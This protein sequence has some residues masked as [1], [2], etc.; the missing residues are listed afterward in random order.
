MTQ[1]AGEIE[2]ENI[3]GTD[4]HYY[5]G[6]YPADARLEYLLLL[7]DEPPTPDPLCPHK[8]LSGLGAHSEL[9][10]PGYAYHP[11]FASAARRY[12]RRLRAGYAARSARRNH[13]LCDGD[14]CVYAS[15]I[16]VLKRRY[17]T[18]YLLDGRDYIEYAHTPAVLDGLIESGEIEPVIAVFVTPPNR[19]QPD[20]PNRTTEYGLNP[21]YARFMAEELVPFVE[22]RYRSLNDPSA[23]LVAGPSYGGLAAAYVPLQ[24]PKVFGLGYS[25]SG[26]LSFGGNALIEAYEQAGPEADSPLCGYWPVR[27]E[28]GAG[29][30][31][32]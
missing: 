16:S 4:V 23:R 2:M 18:I 11:V 14:S 6:V 20:M 12:A 26:Y 8:V 29:V 19:H 9:V 10:M 24:H 21:D 30:A 28:S 32:G 15:R 25:Q 17:P 1:W 7:N 31:S 27:A 13:G 22:E 3:A 5:R